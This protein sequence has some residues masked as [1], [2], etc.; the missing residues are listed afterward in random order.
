MR[1]AVKLST[2]VLFPVLLGMC[3]ITK[4]LV[5]ILLTEKWMPSIPFIV[6]FCILRLF[7]S[8]TSMDKQV[9]LGLGKSQIGMWYE[10]GLLCANLFILAFTVRISVFAIAIGVVAVEFLGSLTLMIISRKVY[11]YR[12]IE[13]IGDFTKPLLNSLIMMVIMWLPTLFVSNNYL[14]LFVQIVIGVLIY[15]LLAKITKD[16]SLHELVGLMSYLITKKIKS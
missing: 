13:R 15:I 2:F 11:S 16:K 1:K 12:L 8:V 3:V 9:Y 4:P 5:L 7:S 10:I 14:L 6:M